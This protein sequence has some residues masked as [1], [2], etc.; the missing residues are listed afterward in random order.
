MGIFGVASHARSRFD[1]ASSCLVLVIL[2][3][4]LMTVRE[5]WAETDAKPEEV[6]LRGKVVPMTEILKAIAPDLKVDDPIAQQ[7]ALWCED[8]T[9]IPLLPDEG[10]RALFRDS[11]LQ[12]RLVEIRGRRFPKLPYL[13]VIGLMVEEGGRMR[14][15]EYYCH[16]C[17]ISLRAPQTCPCCQGPMEFR[18]KPEPR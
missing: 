12:N 18:M 17:A 7:V 5:A 11:R 1:A 8:K 2:V 13:Q 14:R 4:H 10:S 15:P 16:V 6:V 9:V 3:G